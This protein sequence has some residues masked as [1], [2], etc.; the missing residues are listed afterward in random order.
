MGSIFLFL[1]QNVT[2]FPLQSS[3]GFEE[4]CGRC[5]PSSGHKVYRHMVP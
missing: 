5:V 3:L 2:T 4:K 1:G